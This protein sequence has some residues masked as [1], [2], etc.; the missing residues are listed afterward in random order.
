MP[1]VDDDMYAH[2][3]T[4]SIDALSMAYESADIPRLPMIAAILKQFLTLGHGQYI[5]SAAGTRISIPH[6]TT[7]SKLI[8][9]YFYFYA[10]YRHVVKIQNYHDDMIRQTGRTTTR[11]HTDLLLPLAR[12][13]VFMLPTLRH[14]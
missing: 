12:R 14:V 5:D 1:C 4:L 7:P 13:F 10:H 6:A 8:F 9:F 2:F 3:Y 11:R